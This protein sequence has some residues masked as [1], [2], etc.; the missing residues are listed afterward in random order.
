MTGDHLDELRRVAA[1]A[2]RARDN[3]LEFSDNFRRRAE[4][5]GRQARDLTL[6]LEDIERQIAV[7]EARL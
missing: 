6:Q 4:D 3:C 5:R 7:E 2:R 1:V